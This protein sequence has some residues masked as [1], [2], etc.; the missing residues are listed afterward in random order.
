MKLI[1]CWF[2]F[3]ILKFP[4]RKWSKSIWKAVCMWF[5]AFTQLRYAVSE[6]IFQISVLILIALLVTRLS[7]LLCI[8][9]GAIGCCLCSLFSCLFRFCSLYIYYTLVFLKTGSFPP[10]Y[11]PHTLFWCS[12]RWLHSIFFSFHFN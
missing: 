1:C 5:S 9:C 12:H 3:S 4:I 2:E 7:I 8:I 10:A 6:T 11:T